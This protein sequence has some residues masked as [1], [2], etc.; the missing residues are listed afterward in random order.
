MT[1]ESE[2]VKVL[3][4]HEPRL[5]DVPGVEGVGVTGEESDA[6]IAVYVAR[7]TPEVRDRLPAEVDRVPVRVVETGTFEAL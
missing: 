7:D 3:E 6:A 1:T 5:L 4:R 2:A